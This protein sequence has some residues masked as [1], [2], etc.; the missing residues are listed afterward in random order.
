VAT[1]GQV[2]TAALRRYFSV[3]PRSRRYRKGTDLHAAMIEAL[4]C[5]AQY[6][7]YYCPGTQEAFRP[8][9]G[10]ALSYSKHVGGYRIPG[11]LARVISEMSPWHFAAMLGQM[12]D[13]GVT[14]TGDG[15]R[16]FAGMARDQAA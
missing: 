15:E 13:A 2:L 12:V 7:G 10:A 4:Y 14:C 5:A 11:T 1:D 6:P 16:F 8:G 3:G 9:F